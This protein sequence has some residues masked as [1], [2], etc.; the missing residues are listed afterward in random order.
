MDKDPVQR[1]RNW[2]P[3]GNEAPQR[4]ERRLAGDR[5]WQ[6]GVCTA[7]LGTVKEATVSADVQ[8]PPM[9]SPFTLEARVM[10]LRIQ[11]V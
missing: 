2:M 11:N 6:K 4:G 3:Q 8:G 1:K 9:D 5:V 10:I 7:D